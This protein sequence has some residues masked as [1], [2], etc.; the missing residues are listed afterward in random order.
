MTFSFDIPIPDL[1]HERQGNTKTPGVWE[2][3]SGKAGPNVMVSA[4]IHGNEI[5][6]AWALKE[7]LASDLRPANGRLV[8]AFA[9]L[10]A[11]DR[12]DIAS[13]DASRFVDEDLN[14][15]WTA[16]K[17][18]DANSQERRRAL[19]L[20]DWVQAADW[21]LDVHSMHEPSPPLMMTGVLPR[22]IALARRLGIPEH[23]IIDAGHKDGTRMRDYAQFGDAHGEALALLIECGFHGDPASID[24]ARNVIGRFLVESGIVEPSALP[25]SWTLCPKKKQTILEVTHAVVA[26][27]ENLTF[28]Q[29]YQGMECIA[30]AGTKI[31]EQN[32]EP[33]VTPYNDCY[34]VM[35]SLRQLK[36]GVTV[37]RLAREFDEVSLS[38]T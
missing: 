8:L 33:I 32:G 11:F 4:L 5:C 1:S 19:E 27:S 6:G 23:I 34:L 24:T 3:D 12:L 13:H 28:S 22:N 37:V 26:R 2:W 30:T 35:P 20:L 31:G 10:E 16:E 15:V 29:P 38:V 18:N 36:T 7:L 25:E 9:N 14:R 17:L 21:L